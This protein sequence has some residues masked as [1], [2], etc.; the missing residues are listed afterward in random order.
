MGQ[1]LYPIYRRTHMASSLDLD[2]EPGCGRSYSGIW[3]A[4]T[5]KSRGRSGGGAW[6][7]EGE[8]S[9]GLVHQLGTLCSVPLEGSLPSSPAFPWTLCVF[10]RKR[11]DSGHNSASLPSRVSF[12]EAGSICGLH[13]EGSRAPLRAEASAGGQ[14][15][16][17]PPP[18]SPTGLDTAS[19]LCG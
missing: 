16:L 12:R 9:A 14:L 4:L 8:G 5:G 11:R 17:R 13:A 2:P 1:L 10:L 7:G 6:E 15:A 18:P 19:R 3:A